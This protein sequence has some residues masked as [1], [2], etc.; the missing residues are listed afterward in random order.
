MGGDE[1]AVALLVRG[2]GA[3]GCASV[4]GIDSDRHI[5]GSGDEGGV[6][7]PRSTRRAQATRQRPSTKR[8]R[9]ARRPSAVSTV[10]PATP[11][12]VEIQ[13][14]FNDVSGASNGGTG[15]PVAG[16]EVHACNALDVNCANAFGSVTTD[17]AGLAQ[18]HR[19][20]ESSTV[21]TKCT[22]PISPPA[23]SRGLRSTQADAKTGMA[24][25]RCRKGPRSR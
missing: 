8:A 19:P 14:F 18:I 5:V 2:G 3:V 21:T 6:R 16:A 11:G 4:L 17:D 9:R 1:G 15:S 25:S 13:F 20:W 12:N 24:T 7:P 22:P 10:R 23:C